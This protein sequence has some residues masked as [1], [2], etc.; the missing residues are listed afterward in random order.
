MNHND[1]VTTTVTTTETKKQSKQSEEY[2]FTKLKRNKSPS[3]SSMDST[4]D[5][6]D[7]ELRQKYMRA[8]A[9]LRI[10]DE[11]PLMEQ[12]DDDEDQSR[13]ERK[14]YK[15]DGIDIDFVI[16]QAKQVAQLNENTNPERARRILEKVARLEVILTQNQF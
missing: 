10:L 8:V 14:E 1:N 11:A 13:F 3:E 6:F 2:K 5:V 16:Q 4:V 15:T 9:Y 7:S 12:E